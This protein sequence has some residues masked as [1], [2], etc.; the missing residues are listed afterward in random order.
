MLKLIIVFLKKALKY[1]ENLENNRKGLNIKIETVLKIVQD[2]NNVHINTESKSILQISKK[3]EKSNEI[4][5][6]TEPNQDITESHNFNK[7]RISKKNYRRYMQNQALKGLDLSPQD[8]SKNPRKVDNVLQDEDVFIIAGGSSLSD[9]DFNLLK[10]KKTIAINRAC[11]YVINPTAIYWTDKRVYRW[12][13][14]IIDNLSCIKVTSVDD[15]IMNSDITILKRSDDSIFR[16]DRRDLILAG[17]NSGFGA[18]DLAIKMGAKRIFLLGYDMRIMNDKQHFH[19]G[20]PVNLH[21]VE[22]KRVKTNPL[23]GYENMINYFEK[24]GRQFLKH[25]EVYNTNPESG[26]KIYEFYPLE[27]ALN[28][29]Q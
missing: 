7:R 18:I 6:N 15:S 27:K 1:L 29:C 22:L 25:A 11:E 24:H 8:L 9:F 2:L 4:V 16:K 19:E 17:N 23:Y 12:Y 10:D 3:Y 13:K 28:E 26:L 5:D 14:K 20:Y 21:K